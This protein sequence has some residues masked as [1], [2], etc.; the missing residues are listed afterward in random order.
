MRKL[1]TLLALLP[2]S[3]LAAFP[4]V[5]SSI[6]GSADGDATPTQTMPATV[7]ADALLISCVATDTAATVTF[8]TTL[9]TWTNIVNNN[10]GS[11]VRMNCFGLEADGTEDSQTHDLTLGGPI[12]SAWTIY[13]ITGWEDDTVANGTDPGTQSTGTSTTPDPPSNSPP[14]GAGDNLVIAACAN[15]DNDVTTVYS[16]PDNQ[17]SVASTGSFETHMT[18]SSDE[19]T[20]GTDNPG[21][22][23]IGASEEWVCNTIHVEE[24]AAT[25]TPLRRRR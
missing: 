2:A 21:T 14:W 25:N 20:S 23:T 7:S 19:L 1:L 16:L 6:T 8:P 4:T 11:E 12:A 24:G 17:L 15:D 9:G 13:S 10:N 18:V 3:A 22:Y 5:E